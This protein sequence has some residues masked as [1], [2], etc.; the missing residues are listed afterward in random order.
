M[1]ADEKNVSINNQGVDPISKTTNPVANLSGNEPPPSPQPTTQSQPPSTIPPKTINKSY[2][3]FKLT[4]GKKSPNSLVLSARNKTAT[5]R[6]ETES[7]INDLAKNEKDKYASQ[8]AIALLFYSKGLSPQSIQSAIEETEGLTSREKEFLEN[9][10]KIIKGL[11]NINPPRTKLLQTAADFP[12]LEIIE[13]EE[14][15]SPPSNYLVFERVENDFYYSPIIPPPP[16]INETVFPNMQRL[17]DQGFDQGISGSLGKKVI[18]PRIE[19]FKPKTGIESST[20]T[21]AATI[22]AVGV[23]GKAGGPIIS[24]AAFYLAQKGRQTA[25]KVVETITGEHDPRKQAMYISLATMGLGGALGMPLVAAGGLLGFVASGTAAGAGFVSTAAGIAGIISVFLAG[26]GSMLVTLILGSLVI[27]LGIF[28]FV[29]FT[30]IIINSGA[31]LTPPGQ[32][33][34]TLPVPP[35]PS[36]PYID[37]SKTA[38]VDPDTPGSSYLEFDNTYLQPN[39]LTITYTITIVAL[40]DTLQG[41]SFSYNCSVL[42]QGSSPPCPGPPLIPD[43]QGLIISPSQ[44]YTFSYQIT[45]PYDPPNNTFYDTLITDNFTVTA[46]SPSGTQETASATIKIG[47]PPEECPA[48]W[49]V[50]PEGGETYLS[51]TQGPQ[52][53]YS[54]ALTEAI[55]VSA[56]TG[57][58][59]TARHSGMARINYTN[60]DPSYGCYV[61][62]VS[63][64][65]N[66]VFVSRY[67]HLD[68][69]TVQE[70]S[71]VLADQTIGL[72]GGAVGSRCG[73][74]T[75]GSH[76]HF[77]FRDSNN[78]KIYPSDPPPYME[79]GYNWNGTIYNFIPKDV[80]RYCTGSGNCDTTIP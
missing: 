15:F 20:P 6:N 21:T 58:T 38:S 25:G 54:H 24:Q 65:N 50:L 11:E 55:D 71:S 46:N 75:T 13:V 2:L 73:G 56:T 10:T 66:S 31:Y 72:S 78:S 51:I 37:V 33:A 69:I 45:Y 80:P 62:I 36:S 57:H 5:F 32:I 28:L 39:G 74:N 70:G 53:S 14:P 19:G 35:G 79:A 27:F 3:A 47:N 68:S 29:V 64:C 7:I 41:I 8:K 77:E 60:P 49:P 48:G 22:K 63:T 9:T 44:P 67:A 59:I 23:A 42:K 40:Q 34:A 1:A 16:P 26:I 76:L 17:V 52:G 12:K 43:S 18:Q 4:P 30:L 61:D